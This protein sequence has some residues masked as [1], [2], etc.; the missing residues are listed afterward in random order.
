MLTREFNLIVKRL[1]STRHDD[2]CF[3]FQIR[4]LPKLLKEQATVMDGRVRF[5]AYPK[6]HQV[7]LLSILKCLMRKPT[8]AR[9]C[10][11]GELT[12]FTHALTFV[13]HET[14]VGPME[15]L[16]ETVLR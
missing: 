1:A 14:F 10:G 12:S 5:Q 7:M 8:T 11:P 15:G 6:P 16:S 13:S 4:L 9:N 2:T 3:C